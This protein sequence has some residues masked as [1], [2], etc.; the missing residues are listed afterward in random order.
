MRLFGFGRRKKSS[1]E[2]CLEIV[3]VLKAV[4]D[5]ETLAAMGKPLQAVKCFEERLRGIDILKVIGPGDIYDTF[6]AAKKKLD[7]QVN[8]RWV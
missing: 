1:E 6:M 5:F 4:E 2:E 8:G 7:G 3:E